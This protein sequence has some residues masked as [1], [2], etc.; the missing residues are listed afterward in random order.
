MG[1]Q[2]DSPEQSGEQINDGLFRKDDTESGLQ[3]CSLI[4][5]KAPIKELFFFLSNRY[6]NQLV[7]FYFFVCAINVLISLMRLL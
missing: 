7:T 6:Q 3:V 4:N 5:K 2:I 1:R